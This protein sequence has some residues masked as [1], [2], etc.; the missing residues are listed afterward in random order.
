MYMANYPCGSSS[1]SFEHFAQ[2]IRAG[3][4]RYYDY[5]EEKNNEEYGQAHPPLIDLKEI[6]KVPIGLVVGKGD[7]LA[8][9]E[10]AQWLRRTL[11][12]SVLKLYR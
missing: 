12:S 7:Q 11:S 8:T 4:F 6:K 3:R 1:K 2:I 5:G 10:D 9:K